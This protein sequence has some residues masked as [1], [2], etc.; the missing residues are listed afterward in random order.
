MSEDFHK[1]DSTAFFKSAIEDDTWSK[2]K[3]LIKTYH[4]CIYVCW[5]WNS[6]PL[7]NF[8]MIKHS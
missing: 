7:V 6:I 3:L 2:P 5:V 4:G 8:K 1:G